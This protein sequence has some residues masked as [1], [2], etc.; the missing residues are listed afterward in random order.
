MP[1]ILVATK[2]DALFEER[3][4]EP[5]QIESTAKRSIKNL[6]TMQTS[7]GVPE[8]HKRTLS[9]ILRS[10]IAAPKG[11]VGTPKHPPFQIAFCRATT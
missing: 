4:V 7:A 2:N 5:T 8:T 11:K 1:I 6:L 9:M 3:E 10:I